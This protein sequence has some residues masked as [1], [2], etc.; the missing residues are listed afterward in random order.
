M[1]THRMDQ[2]T[3]ERLL[4]GSVPDGRDGLG[5]LVRLLAAVRA[6]PR[7]YELLGEAAAVRAFRMTYA[8][9]APTHPGR[10]P[11]SWH[12]PGSPPDVVAAPAAVTPAAEPDPAG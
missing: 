11:G 7:P 6:A 1:D 5:M 4:V 9:A 12:R 3:V 8:G 2:E 10:V